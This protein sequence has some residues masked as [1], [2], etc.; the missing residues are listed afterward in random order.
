ME[1]NGL[2]E[3]RSGLGNN[4]KKRVMQVEDKKKKSP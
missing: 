3:K 1:E 2:I 4:K